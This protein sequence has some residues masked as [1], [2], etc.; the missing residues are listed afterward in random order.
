VHRRLAVS[1]RYFGYGAA[2]F[3]LFQ[4]LTR[5]PAVQLIQLNFGPLLRSSGP[6][7]WGW[8]VCLAL[9][10]GLFEEVGRYLGYRVLLRRE[11]RTWNKA[12]MFGL[13]HGGFESMVLTSGLML[14]T[15]FNVQALLG[16]GL[17]QLPPEQRAPAA[18]QLALI[19]AHPWL[20]P[21]LAAF[22]RLWTVPIQVAFSV[23][24]LQ[25]FV[26]GSLSWLWLAIAAHTVVDLVAVG[27]PQLLGQSITTMLLTE[28][29]V[30]GW[31]I[32][33]LW[34]IWALR[35]PVPRS[36]TVSPPVPSAAPA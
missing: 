11:A 17:E 8:L 30:A 4:G 14:L 34:I 31:G 20:F 33:G 29:V 32:I 9:T 1:W 36:A 3:L 15:V 27:L 22:E 2:I 25:V 12:I 6:L 21:A 5:I 23:L 7:L 19:A 26:R 16:G 35:D 13:G 24:V 18:D 10:A 28:A